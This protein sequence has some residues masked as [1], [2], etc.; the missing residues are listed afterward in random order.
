MAYRVQLDLAVAGTFAD[1][2]HRS[3]VA[4]RQ[5]VTRQSHSHSHP[6]PPHP[7]PP[8]QPSPSQE[9]GGY[10]LVSV[11]QHPQEA[12]LGD[13][14]MNINP[15]PEAPTQQVIDRE[16]PRSQEQ[17]AAP[18]EDSE[19]GLSFENTY[20]PVDNKEQVQVG[21]NLERL[22]ELSPDERSRVARISFANEN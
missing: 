4:F 16:S 2:L 10:A 12:S 17:A 20:Q 8:H 15:S 7:Q 5:P 22:E 21:E 6:H 14:E 19:I 11:N 9:K 13:V 1:F 18:L 3:N